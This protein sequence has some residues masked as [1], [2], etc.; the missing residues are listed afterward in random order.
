M[1]VYGKHIVE[2]VLAKYQDKITTIYLAKEI[3]KGFFH[4][5][6]K[7]QKPIVRVDSK[8][9]QAFARGG[10]HQGYLLE[11]SPLE[12]AEFSYVKSMDFVLVLCGIS[13]VGNLGS[14]FRSA[15]ALG[16]DGI[17]ICGIRDLKQEGVLRASSGAM[18][19]MPFCVVYNPLDALH[20]L[21]QA[22]FT[23]LGTSLQGQNLQDSLEGK[24]ALVL[25]SEG[26][27]LPKRVLAKMD[28]NLTIPMKRE[29]DS[30]NVGVAGAIL[31]DRI[32]N[33]RD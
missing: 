11:I 21:K 4:Q 26:E 5:L 15:Y 23:L 24:K 16:V 27:G 18:L 31:I 22:G 32:I 7:T 33:G 6:K 9:A 28:Y 14:L 13:D 29:F 10:N 19:G 30:L 1:V 3:D 17:V 20:E 8:K 25:G 12:S 2:L